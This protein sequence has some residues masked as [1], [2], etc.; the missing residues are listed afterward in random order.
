MVNEKFII[1]DIVKLKKKYSRRKYTV[2][3]ISEDGKYIWITPEKKQKKK[4]EIRKFKKDSL[5]LISR[6]QMFLGV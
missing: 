2:V 3:S 1:G 5:T 4:Q 6:N